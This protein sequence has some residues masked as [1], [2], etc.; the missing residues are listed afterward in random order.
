MPVEIVIAA[1]RLSRILMILALGVVFVPAHT[2][3]PTQ[4]PTGKSYSSL[5]IPRP[6]ST[7]PQFPS[8]V[9]FADF[10][11]ASG[12]GFVHSASVTNTKFLPET[13]GAGVA[14]LDFDNDGRLDLF[15]TN[16]ASIGEEN[17]KN[18]LPEKTDAKYWNRLYRQKNDGTFEDVTEKAGVK[19]SIESW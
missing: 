11:S 15:F 1:R 5:D 7:A 3:T 16:G 2:P 10:S 18:K 6:T 12:I 8:P 17:P 19:G 13:M 9:T 4:S 14:M